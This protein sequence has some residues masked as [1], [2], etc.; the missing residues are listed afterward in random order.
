MDSEPSDF[1]AEKI[2]NP[3]LYRIAAQPSGGAASVLIEVNLPPQ[4]VQIDRRSPAHAGAPRRWLLEESAEQQESNQRTIEQAGLSLR[5]LLGEAPH[6][7]NSARAFV[8][9]VTSEQLREIARSPLIK[10]IHLN[11]NLKAK[12]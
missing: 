4:Q 12:H 7:I 6:W 9:R 10:T 8:A 5:E 11:R 3:E 1:P 2:P